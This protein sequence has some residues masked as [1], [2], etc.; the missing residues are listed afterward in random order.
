[1][2]I[3][4]NIPIQFHVSNVLI[5]PDT[6]EGKAKEIS[7]RKLTRVSTKPVIWTTIGMNHGPSTNKNRREAT[8]NNAYH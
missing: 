7:V 4:T 1:M 2:K 6:P 5:I 3:P 8:P